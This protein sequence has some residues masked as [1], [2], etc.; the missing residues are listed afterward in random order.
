MRKQAQTTLYNVDNNNC[1]IKFKGSKKTTRVVIPDG[2][3]AIGANVFKEYKSIATVIIPNSVV[4]IGDG[5][6]S[7]CTS[8]KEVIIPDSVVSIGDYAFFHCTSL[9]ELILPNGVIS[10]GDSAFEGCR[11]LS[12]VKLPD[13]VKSIG[14]NLF[15][16]CSSLVYISIPDSIAE[17]SEGLFASCENLIDVVIPESVTAIGKNAF[18]LCLSLED[19]IIPDSVTKIGQRAFSNCTSLIEVNI[20]YG[21]SS[22]EAAT[23][24]MC[25]SL[26]N[27]NIPDSITSIDDEAFCECTS[28]R[29]I[30]I[31]DS[32]NYIGYHAFDACPARRHIDIPK[33]QK[34]FVCIG[35]EGLPAVFIP[36]SITSIEQDAFAE[37]ANIKAIY[38]DKEKN[39]LDLSDID[40]PYG[41]KIH[42]RD[43]SVGKVRDKN[44]DGRVDT[45]RK[46]QA[47]TILDEMYR[48][49]KVGM[50]EGI[51]NKTLIELSYNSNRIEG[52]LLTQEQVK[53]IFDTNKVTPNLGSVDIDDIVRIVNHFYAFDTVLDKA[54]TTLTEKFIKELHVILESGTSYSR[55]CGSC[56]GEYKTIPNEFVGTYTTLPE[57]VPG[58]MKNL[59]SEYN[60]ISCKTI[61]DI[62]DFYIKFE[63]I[64]PFQYGSGKVGRLIMFKECLKYNI[65]PFIIDN[66]F[67]MFL[68]E[69]LTKSTQDG[70]SLHNMCIALQD[71]YKI[72][73]LWD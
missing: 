55:K 65:T 25:T 32:V 46:K 61:D 63:R 13:C 69:T 23:F 66:E 29:S 53:T 5:A 60:S 16:F 38:I 36:D 51:Y 7:D 14:K 11:S 72:D 4:S 28:L 48:Q 35:C 45:N 70:R 50:T 26:S 57:N 6:F 10:I 68:F 58:D 73:M 34:E 24:D 49:K 64:Q 17:I 2:I 71:K 52:C 3:T 40:I 18:T 39:S 62:I 19:I 42:W 33:Q 22:I 20:P 8:L 41:A 43:E 9:K 21:V 47:K 56:I 67:K 44:T 54:K 12:Y 15:S 30:V 27:V 1:I 59:L 37:C 31:P